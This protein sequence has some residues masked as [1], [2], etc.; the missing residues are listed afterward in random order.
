MGGPNLSFRPY[1]RK[2]F[3]V[4]SIADSSVLINRQID[5][6]KHKNILFFAHNGPSGLGDKRDNIWGC[7][8]KKGEGDFGDPDL[9]ASIAYARSKDKN[10]LA[11]IAG[12]MHHGLKGGGQRRG[13]RRKRHPL[14]QCGQGPVA[15]KTGETL[16]HHVRLELSSDG[17]SVSPW[18]S[19]SNHNHDKCWRL[20]C[21]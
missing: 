16:H 19:A 5:Q 21:R 20:G 11:V 18:K 10:I 6:S 1:L 17:V 7:D 12:H 13:T 4:D 2:V 14:H 3:K 9:E 8:F 15:R